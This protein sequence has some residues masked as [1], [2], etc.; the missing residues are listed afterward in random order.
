MHSIRIKARNMSEGMPYPDAFRYQAVCAP[1]G[2]QSEWNCARTTAE[3][4][5][6]WHSQRS[7]PRS[8]QQRQEASVP[9]CGQVDFHDLTTGHIDLHGPDCHQ[10]WWVVLTGIGLAKRI[11]VEIHLMT[12]IEARECPDVDDELV[13]AIHA[14]VQEHGPWLNEHTDYFYGLL[15]QLVRVSKPSQSPPRRPGA[16][17]LSS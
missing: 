8:D 5:G 9:G 11:P 2:W 13:T 14:V 1:C 10:A 4:D 7:C 16:K 17:V 6:M 3:H 15:D 12:S